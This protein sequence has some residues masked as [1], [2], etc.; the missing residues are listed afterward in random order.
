M[1]SSAA[2][3]GS[4]WSELAGSVFLPEKDPIVFSLAGGRRELSR[5]SATLP[6]MMF[7]PGTVTR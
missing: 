5:C 4:S 6:L 7:K 2:V 3:V 1:T